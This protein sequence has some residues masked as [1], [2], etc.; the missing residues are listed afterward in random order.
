MVHQ[1]DWNVQCKKGILSPASGN[2]TSILSS[3]SSCLVFYLLLVCVPFGSF[4][5]PLRLQFL[6]LLVPWFLSKKMFNEH[7]ISISSVSQQISAKI[8]EYLL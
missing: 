3:V 6:K 8:K 2:V 5:L 7:D 4:L 1:S